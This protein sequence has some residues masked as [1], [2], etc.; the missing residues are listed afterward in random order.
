MSVSNA[1]DWLVVI[2]S[3]GTL[4]VLGVDPE[5]TACG[6]PGTY[7]VCLGPDGP[8]CPGCVRTCRIPVPAGLARGDEFIVRGVAKR[9]RKA[10]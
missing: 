1:S 7:R 10:T 8:I 6:R 5:L 2:G 9:G 3:E 4:P